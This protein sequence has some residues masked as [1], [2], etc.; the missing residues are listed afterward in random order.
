[1]VALLSTVDTMDVTKTGSV[2][3]SQVSEETW[4]NRGDQG[5][6]K[7]NNNKVISGAIA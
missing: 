3:L 1:M 4:L 5:K 2:I 7:E 6:G